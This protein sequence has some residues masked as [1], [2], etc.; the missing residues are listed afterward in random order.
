MSLSPEVKAQFE[1]FVSQHSRELSGGAVPILMP[2]EV[3]LLLMV[4]DQESIT[5]PHHV[6]HEELYSIIF[7][8]ML[9]FR[10]PD[11]HLSSVA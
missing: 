6:T 1:D 7:S 3:R 11:P 9:A 8:R 5:L 10:R 2:R 4:A